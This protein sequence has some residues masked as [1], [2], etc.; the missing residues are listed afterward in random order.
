MPN[1]NEWTLGGLISSAKL[2]RNNPTPTPTPPPNQVILLSSA[3]N[4]GGF[5][6]ASMAG[7]TSSG[8]TFVIDNVNPHSGWYYVKGTSASEAKFYRYFDLTQYQIAINDGRVSSSWKVYIDVGDS[9][10][11]TYIVRFL[12]SSNNILYSYNTGWSWHDGGYD[13]WGGHLDQ[14]P[15]NTAKVYVEFRMRRSSGDFTDCDVDDFYL[16]L[17]IEPEIQPTPTPTLTPTPIPDCLSTYPT[18]IMLYDYSYCSE[19]AGILPINVTKTLFN[20]S[21]YNWNN[22]TSSLKIPNGWSMIAYEGDN[23]TGD[24]VCIN[25]SFND[26][27]SL[28]FPN[29]NSVNNNISSIVGYG[30]RDCPKIE[31]DNFTY[32]ENP[33]AGETITASYSIKNISGRTLSFDGILVGVHGPYCETWDC[34]NISDFPWSE[35]ISLAN[36]ESY[37]YSKTRAFYIPNDQYLLEFLTLESNGE[38]KSYISTITFEV[39]RG[40]EITE[41]VTLTPPIP[42]VGQEVNAQFTIK[43]FGARAITIPHLMVIAKGPN[44]ESWDCP[45]GWADYPWVDD[46]TLDPGEEYTYSQMRPFNKAGEGYFADAA[47]GDNNFWWYEVPNNI[48]YEFHVFEPLKI[49]I[50]LV[51]R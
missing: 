19:N 27:S 48:R 50:P 30:N 1:L 9:E 37:L 22:K 51:T 11:F 16:D 23:G 38:W 21:E 34:P 12:D 49:Y 32:S 13:D 42:F 45:D 17:F 26:L 28:Q 36:G 46:L 47:F 33:L 35:D 31:A 7:W 20:L 40:I 39:D 43:N 24:W 29:G 18:S 25:S 14:L 5:E 15:A 8:G 6:N 44:C 4:N 10:Q 2:I 41:P 3:I